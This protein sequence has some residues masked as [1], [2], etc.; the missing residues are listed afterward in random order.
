[1]QERSR[2][3]AMVYSGMYAGSIAGLS[4]SPHMVQWLGWPS[5]FF[6]FGS[7]GLVWFALWLNKAESSP[8]QDS[9]VSEKERAYI[10]GNTVEPVSASAGP[11]GLGKGLNRPQP[12]YSSIGASMF[13]L[14]EHTCAVMHSG[15]G[16]H[17]RR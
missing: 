13:G 17:W 5:V 4:L 12:K 10:K 7:L 14:L 11:E 6:I 8:S 3:L 2:S 9:R 1:M 16:V 15:M